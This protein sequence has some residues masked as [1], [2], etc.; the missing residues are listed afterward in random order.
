[1]KVLRFEKLRDTSLARG[2]GLLLVAAL[3]ALVAV[4]CGGGESGEA[5]AVEGTIQATTTTTQITDMVESI[6]GDEVEVTALM[7]P[8]VDPHLYEPS[9]GDIEA[10]QGADAVFYNGL[11]LEGQ[12]ADLLVQV[13][14][15][16]P[17]VRVTEAI[18]EDELR[19]SEN[20]EGQNDPHVWFAPELWETAV[21][22]VVEQLSE[23]KPDSAE[24]FEQNGE[25]YKQEVREAHEYVQERIEEIPEDNRVL[26]TAHDAF[27]YF[28]ETYGVEVQAL[29]GISTESEAGAGD[30]R[31][32]ANELVEDEIPALFTES[33]IP[34]RNIEAVQ[35][36]AQ[37]QGWDL[38]IGGELYADA[39]GD[40]DTEEGTYPGMMR[41]NADTMAEA[42]G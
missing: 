5:R 26:V 23:L 6:G 27:G 13:G 25:E 20:Y 10:L 36:A 41:A 35:A 22:P 31:E 15:E 24:T 32:L 29:Q 28:G 12:L 42:L 2:F 16:S 1:M 34:R 17:T 14:Q 9:Q 11:F 8:G 40:P 39:M 7:G 4:G 18:P 37:D 21:D 19:P 30:V 33:S 3:A 38:E